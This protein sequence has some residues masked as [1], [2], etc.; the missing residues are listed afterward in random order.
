MDDDDTPM[1]D[2]DSSITNNSNINN[3]NNNSN[4]SLKYSNRRETTTTTTTTTAGAINRNNS[5]N[6]NTN[7]NHSNGLDIKSIQN[8]IQE[9][10]INTL[11]SELYQQFGLTGKGVIRNSSNNENDNNNNDEISNHLN[12]I[13]EQILSLHQKQIELLTNRYSSMVETKFQELEDNLR[14]NIQVKFDTEMAF[15]NSSNSNSNVNSTP[16][17]LMNASLSKLKRKLVI[18][19]EFDQETLLK[20][21]KTLIEKEFPQEIKN[22]EEDLVEIDTRILKVKEMLHNMSRFRSSKTSTLYNSGSN[23]N[24]NNSSNSNSN[25]SSTTTSSGDKVPTYL[26]YRLTDGKFVQLICQTCKRDKYLSAIGFVNHCRIAHSIKYTSTDHAAEVCGIH[27]DESK[28]PLDDPCRS[29]PLQI[30]K[31]SSSS[32]TT[33]T[34]KPTTTTTTTT[35]KSLQLD[36]PLTD[37]T[38]PILNP[39]SRF[40]IK[41]RIIVGN[42]STQISPERR[43]GDKSTHKWM[44]YVRGPSMESDISY[45]VK[46]VWIYLHESFAPN[47]IIEISNPPF[48]LTKRGWGEFPLRIKLFFHDTKNKPIDIIHNLKL[49]QIPIQYGVTKLGAETVVDIDLDRYFFDKRERMQ[50][51]LENNKDEKSNNDSNHEKSERSE[52][53]EKSTDNNNNENDNN[54]N[55]NNF[56]DDYDDRC[57]KIDPDDF[58]QPIGS[59]NKNDDE[60][61]EKKEKSMDKE[62]RD[63]DS[64][65]N[66]PIKK[67]LVK[68][69]ASS[70]STTTTTLSSNTTTTTTTTGNN[71]LLGKSLTNIQKELRLKK[72]KEALIVQEMK[73]EKERE[74]ENIKKKKL[75][76]QERE[77]EQERKEREK[78]LERIEKEKEKIEREKEHIEKEREK[79]EKEREA[80]ERERNEKDRLEKLLKSNTVTT[81]LPPI[82]RAPLVGGA[83]S[84]PPLISPLTPS[85]S[86]STTTT[87]TTPTTGSASK[88]KKTLKSESIHNLLLRLASKYPIISST[89]TIKT[90]SYRIAPT[91][92]VWLK[93]T[94]G[95]QKST[96]YRRAKV[97]KR[98][99]KKKSQKEFSIKSIMKWCRENHFTPL[100]PSQEERYSIKDTFIDPPKVVNTPSDS[101]ATPPTA[102]DSN[103]SLATI[104]TTP[105]TTDQTMSIASIEG[106]QIQQEQQ[107]QQQPAQQDVQELIQQEHQQIQ[108]QQQELP[109][110]NHH[111]PIIPSPPMDVNMVL[112]EDAHSLFSSSGGHHDDLESQFILQHQFDH[113]SHHNNHHH[114]HLHSLM[115]MDSLHVGPSPMEHPDS[116]LSTFPSAIDDLSLPPPKPKKPSKYVKKADREIEA[117]ANKPPL[118][119][120]PILPISEESINSAT[121]VPHI[122]PN[123]HQQPESTTNVESSQP[124]PNV[125]QEQ[126]NN[127]DIDKNTDFPFHQHDEGSH[128]G[129]E[130]LSSQSILNQPP[131]PQ[132]ILNQPPTPQPIINQPPTPQ[133]IH[134]QPPTP[135]PIINQPPTPQSILN[136]PPTPQPIINQP[137]TPQPIHNQ[138]PTPQNTTD[139]PIDHHPSSSSTTN[140]D[141]NQVYDFPLIETSLLTPLTPEP[142]HNLMSPHHPQDHNHHHHLHHQQ[143]NIQHQQ[144][145]QQHYQ[146][147]QI[148]P[149]NQQHN[150]YQQQQYNSYQQQQ[151]QQQPI[152]PNQPKTISV[153]HIQMFSGWDLSLFKPPIVNPTLRPNLPPGK[154]TLGPY[155]LFYCKFCGTGHQ[156]DQFDQKQKHCSQSFVQSSYT[157]L[158]KSYPNIRITY[159]YNFDPESKSPN[160][161]AKSS[162]HFLQ[163]NV[164]HYDRYQIEWISY[165][166]KLINIPRI[167]DTPP[168]Y[169]AEEV[170]YYSTFLFMTELIVDTLE[171]YQNER[172]K[173]PKEEC[174][175][176]MIVP[177]HLHT[178]IKNNNLFNFLSNVAFYRD[179]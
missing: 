128:L 161:N 53:D 125:E 62:N 103:T 109:V 29:L 169:E 22:K 166:M 76:E 32:S 9:S 37:P 137:P 107:Q 100:T 159:P 101:L 121:V 110:I 129:G 85:K 27:V 44:V 56:D 20:R 51:M 50:K 150:N 132:S 131:T 90:L 1:N 54:N 26:Y 45:F 36:I 8:E 91:K 63:K 74:R 86:T 165:I 79:L 179:K 177:P 33:P 105:T 87:T 104:A 168:D 39:S 93:W 61:Q 7:V 57:E 123:T 64:L 136:Q 75:E 152:D 69:K 81:I 84:S 78:E 11:K 28:I 127:M 97:L 102:N 89:H 47:D 38:E 139:T 106:N 114:D 120:I 113:E 82:L 142:Q 23:N 17:S 14:N 77:K 42:T 48:H 2:V 141:D 65:L 96:E 41:K 140:M 88:K 157:S 72:E 99:L 111:H 108:Q 145:P 34:S 68:P 143:Q 15:N 167:C 119:I 80:L 130:Q 52:K 147:Q 49:V 13:S 153:P 25:S 164:Y 155:P 6:S 135:Q 170:L 171:V 160:P 10:V 35:S 172:E 158:A 43:G 112:H 178:A 70:L 12:L 40:Y 5:N 60:E 46:K 58:D 59:S 3:S 144:H 156:P 122:E 138:P 162:V 126:N 117:N 24:N 30:Y 31:S 133:P 175:I 18:N 148:Q 66:S 115:P 173:E 98:I 19:N 16:F 151:Q 154:K 21:L 118:D 116:L 92:A 83:L 134:N 174:I 163:N 73:K 71:G 149:Y 55:N 67:D 4:N 146:N 95:K 176:K 124:F 94:L